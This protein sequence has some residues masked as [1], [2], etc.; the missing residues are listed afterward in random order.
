MNLLV[1]FFDP[2]LWDNVVVQYFKLC[3]IPTATTQHGVMLKYRNDFKLDFCAPEFSSFVSDYFLIWNTFTKKQA[4]MA[5]IPNEKLI[6]CGISRCL[7]KKTLNNNINNNRF[8]VILDGKFTKEN[9]WKMVLL[10]EDLAQLLKSSFVLRIHPSD[11]QSDYS[12]Y[13]KSSYCL[14]FSNETDIE[15]YVSSV[16]F[17]IV[18][19]S[20]ALFEFVF[21]RHRFLRVKP[22]DGDLDKYTDSKIINIDSASMGLKI[23]NNYQFERLIEFSNIDE[24]ALSY[25]KFFNNFI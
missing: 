5:G 22:I 4:I 25:K 23:L 6:V 24:I 17:S 8:G 1:V 19:N 10:A 21:Y 3:K 11:D 13:I 16:D 7:F 12:E 9:N 2:P 14:G 20:T 15:E 18:C